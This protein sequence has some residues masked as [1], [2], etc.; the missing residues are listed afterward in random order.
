MERQ[1]AYLKLRASSPYS[2][3]EERTL[4]RLESG[5]LLAEIRH[6]QSDFLTA[7][8]GEPPHDRLTDVAAAFE[9]LVDQLERVSRA[10]R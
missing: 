10:P 7:T 9:R 6:R 5:A 1:A 8:K 3:E 4:A 2:T